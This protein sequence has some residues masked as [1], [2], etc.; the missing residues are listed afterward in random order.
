M[1]V[2]NEGKIIERCIR[3]AAPLLD[4]ICICDTGSTDDTREVVERVARELQLPCKIVD[5]SPFID[6]GTNRT[7]SFTE[8]RAYITKELGWYPAWS[9]ALLSDADM[10]LKIGQS[11]SELIEG[12]PAQPQRFSKKL[13]R[14]DLFTHYLLDQVNGQ[15][16]Y[17]NVRLLRFDVDW[18]CVGKTHEYWGGGGNAGNMS[19]LCYD[20]RDDGGC[21]Q[22]KLERDIRLL[23]ATLEEKPNDGRTL[24][25]LG[26]TLKDTGA[27][28]EG[29]AL[30]EQRAK[31]N[32]FAE[33]AFYA[34]I[35]A[36]NAHA[37]RGAWP[38][39]ADAYMRAWNKRPHRAEPLVKLA[40]HYRERG[41]NHLAMLFA[42]EAA[43]T[44]RD[45]KGDLLFIDYTLHEYAI[46]YEISI[47]G[48][49][50]EAHR[51]A[52]FDACDR[53]LHARA[54]EPI[55]QS[56]RTNVLFYLAT[57]KN[58]GAQVHKLTKPRAV[59][60]NWRALNPSVANIGDF[61]L[62]NI[63]CVNYHHEPRSGTYAIL[64][65]SGKIRTRNVLR[66]LRADSLEAFGPDVEIQ[67]EVGQD[68]QPSQVVGLE[69]ARIF[70]LPDGRLAFNTAT[71]VDRDL[72]QQVLCITDL[73][74]SEAL[75]A[76][77]FPSK[78][79][80]THKV[81]LQSEN[82]NACEK[83]WLYVGGQEN[84]VR[85]I[86]SHDPPVVLEYD[87]ADALPGVSHCV[88][89]R[90]EIGKSAW[91]ARYVSKHYRGSGSPARIP[92]ELLQS[93]RGAV[94][95]GLTKAGVASDGASA[96][97]A[98][99]VTHE[100]V[101]KPYRV[102]LHRI[103]AYDSNGKVL[104]ATRPFKLCSE[105]VEYCAG[106]AFLGNEFAISFGYEDASAEIMRVKPDLLLA[107][108]SRTK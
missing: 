44:P 19:M 22:D 16:K 81:V 12:K 4:A 5:D 3:A 21:K 103:C 92:A 56:A 18:K 8:A 70:W 95:R 55:L 34:L 82:P 61:L 84:K 40:K 63:R 2:K 26:R 29:V 78:V 32:D 35:E 65:E 48:Y 1:I 46:D 71:R 53:M 85:F 30:L 36:G 37:S 94:Q 87:L 91:T 42:L 45:A 49:Y 24:F 9:F 60:D 96:V 69:D 23:R 76:D 66:A 7:H 50:V 79:V 88:H 39:A 31:L 54:P 20:D 106:C 86:Y 105:T 68:F 13:L 17:A 75:D 58:S 57:L 62:C 43:K 67:D 98:L 107:L 6:F 51:D 97:E 33:E 80:V 15:L 101:F 14:P 27:Y 93:V 104:Y 108:L 47:A 28:E 74:Q 59:P 52:A 99:G 72:P 64:D 83:N 77:T 38:K 102:Y 11:S 25:Y 100:V 90:V 89:K 73:K 10:I 41:E